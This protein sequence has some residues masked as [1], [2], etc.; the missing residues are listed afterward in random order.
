MEAEI[1]VTVGR[2]IPR[3]IN[4]WQLEISYLKLSGR[5]DLVD[6]D[7]INGCALEQA[8]AEEAMVCLGAMRCARG[9][10][11]SEVGKG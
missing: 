1:S 7:C 11:H 6:T 9:G 3:T 4:S 2:H 8:F 10:R 5:I